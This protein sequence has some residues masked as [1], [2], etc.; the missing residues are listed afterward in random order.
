[1]NASAEWC[2]GSLRGT[3]D[4]IVPVKKHFSASVLQDDVDGIAIGPGLV[5]SHRGFVRKPWRSRSKSLVVN[6]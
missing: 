1:M 2:L 3:P 6:H 4:K 5:G